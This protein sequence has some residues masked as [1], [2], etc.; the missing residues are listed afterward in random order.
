MYQYIQT[1]LNYYNRNI[2]QERI[3]FRNEEEL[4]MVHLQ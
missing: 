2:F 4:L 3:I 1:Q